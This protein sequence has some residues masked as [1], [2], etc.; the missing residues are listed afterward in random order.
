M[1]KSEKPAEHDSKEN[2]EEDSTE[3]NRAPRQKSEHRNPVDSAE[4]TKNIPTQHGAL[5]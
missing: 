5:K 4:K 2:K 1:N 3:F